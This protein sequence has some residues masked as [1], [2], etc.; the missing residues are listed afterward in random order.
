MF[1]ARNDAGCR[2][3]QAR[4]AE[5]YRRITSRKHDNEHPLTVVFV[6]L[7]DDLED[8]CDC[9]DGQSGG[10]GG[11]T[12]SRR[13]TSSSSSLAAAMPAEWLGVPFRVDHHSGT[14]TTS[15][16]REKLAQQFGAQGSRPPVCRLVD[17]STGEVV[18][19]NVCAAI[20][21]DPNGDGFPWG[22]SLAAAQALCRSGLF[23]AAAGVVNNF[24]A[25]VRE[26]VGCVVSN[27]GGGVHAAHAAGPGPAWLGAGTSAIGREAAARAWV[28]R[29][30]AAVVRFV[31]Q[32]CLQVPKQQ[33]RA[34][35]AGT[36][37]AAAAER[38]LQER[39]LALEV[40]GYAPDHGLCTAR[41][42]TA[43]LWQ[44]LCD[45]LR[46]VD[47]PL[48]GSSTG[49]TSTS[50]ALD[51]VEDIVRKRALDATTGRFGDVA[52]VG[53]SADA[54]LPSPV[55][56]L[57][58][59]AL[60]PMRREG[61]WRQ[62][63]P[64]AARAGTV[65]LRR[66]LSPFASAEQ[67]AAPDELLSVLLRVHGGLAAQAK[68]PLTAPNARAAAV[69]VATLARDCAGAVF[70]S[71]RAAASQLLRAAGVES[72]DDEVWSPVHELRKPFGRQ[73]INRFVVAHVGIRVPPQPLCFIRD[74]ANPGFVE[75]PHC[76]VA[77]VVAVCVAPLLCTFACMMTHTH[78]H[79]RCNRYKAMLRRLQ[80]KD[81]GFP[82]EFRVLL[83]F[84]RGTVPVRLL[85]V[86]DALPRSSN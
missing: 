59:P 43:A 62:S 1:F 14:G 37:A 81:T 82:R 84:A 44:C 85:R 70:A 51:V 42:R 61:D 19:P 21:A 49:I 11:T 57:F 65:L 60:P 71:S 13:R 6:Y 25:S 68:E 32:L 74:C 2:A 41:A 24:G 63:E 54:L 26:Q 67:L 45:L 16:L 47:G 75:L 27:C 15:D 38:F 36:A 18:C 30:T 78:T 55:A 5:A 23:E 29:Q 52:A 12:S 64:D 73:T 7:D 58:I 22:R 40:G 86:V 48:N 31:A 80:R 8:F 72:D 20:A 35:R 33:S 83:Q 66:V 50:F 17:P 77:I 9:I 56:A 79:T 69:A 46:M 3:F 39:F 10:G 76:A 34:S 28:H 4:L 53:L